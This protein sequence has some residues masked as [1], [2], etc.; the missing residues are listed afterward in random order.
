MSSRGRERRWRKLCHPRSGAWGG[1][2]VGIRGAGGSVVVE[3]VGE[4]AVVKGFV[5]EKK[6]AY[7]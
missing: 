7:T 3:Q 5:S 1:Q 2:E 4:V 6:K